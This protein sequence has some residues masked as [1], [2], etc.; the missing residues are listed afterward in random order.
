MTNLP[1]DPD[2]PG[3]A[4]PVPEVP[5]AKSN[6]PEQTYIPDFAPPDDPERA[7]D[8]DK[9][10]EVVQGDPIVHPDRPSIRSADAP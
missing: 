9:R 6:D 1:T 10:Q 5:P 8:V 4:R 7:R 2:R 3:S